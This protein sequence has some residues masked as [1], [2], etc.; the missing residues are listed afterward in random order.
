MQN[1]ALMLYIFFGQDTL[2]NG[3]VVIPALPY[4]IG[5]FLGQEELTYT[6]PIFS[7]GR[8]VCVGR[9]SPAV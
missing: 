7:R 4:F 6:L 9:P 1:E 5:L 8:P 3:H 2:P